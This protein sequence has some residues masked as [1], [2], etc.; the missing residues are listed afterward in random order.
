MI[1]TLEP[2]VSAEDIFESLQPEDEQNP[3]R[4]FEIHR[5][6]KLDRII[7]E[8]E[9]F[10]K[11]GLFTDY[12]SYYTFVEKIAPKSCTSKLIQE[13]LLF[14]IDNFQRLQDPRVRATM[15]EL[16]GIYISPM[17]NKSDEKKVSIS[18]N[19]FNSSNGFNIKEV[20]RSIGFLKRNKILE[21][22]GDVGIF[23][24]R[25]MKKATIIVNGNCD[26]YCG[27]R[28]L[29]GN[30]TVYGNCGSHIGE[31]MQGGKINLNGDYKSISRKISG[32]DI[33]Y[34]GKQIIKDGDAIPGAEI[35]WY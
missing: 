2:I 30:I 12:E 21:I 7:K 20:P 34:R 15:L 14:E 27:Y 13:F 22:N 3:E 19:H 16:Y 11:K 24:G 8:F 18:T 5:S 10:S 9:A 28:M 4:R 6:P 29:N 23:L 25:L 31:Q 32:G 26:M 33:Y 35:K 17:V 1:T